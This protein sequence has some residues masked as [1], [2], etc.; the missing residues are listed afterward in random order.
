MI[1]TTPTSRRRLEGL[2]RIFQFNRRFYTWA[3]LVLL[4]GGIALAGLV[5]LPSFPNWLFAG[6]FLGWLLALWWVFGSL[7]VS[8]W[9]YDRSDLYRFDW[10]RQ[11]V[12]DNDPPPDATIVHAGYDEVSALLDETFPEMEWTTLDFHD[13]VIMPEPSIV[14]AREKYPPPG[15]QKAITYLDWGDH[16]TSLVLFPLTAHELR[17]PEQRRELLRQA[18]KACHKIVLVEHLRDLP[19]LVAF[20]P[21]FFHFHSPKSWENDIGKSGLQIEKTFRISPFIRCYILSPGN[22]SRESQDTPNHR[23][24]P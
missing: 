6:G 3:G 15:N 14:I 7:I 23:P 21:G 9:I 13:P 12:W 24:G 16:K 22:D 4:G 20:G 8:H 19:N 18:G 5:T 2:I 10:L 11:K 1:R 17:L